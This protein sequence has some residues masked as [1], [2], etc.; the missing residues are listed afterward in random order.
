MIKL[1]LLLFIIMIIVDCMAYGAYLY[2]YIMLKDKSVK[3]EVI[4]LSAVAILSLYWLIT[5]LL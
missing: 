3:Q 4:I 5:T 1:F 2:I